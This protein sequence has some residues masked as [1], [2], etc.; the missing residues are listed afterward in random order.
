MFCLFCFLAST[1]KYKWIIICLTWN[2][3]KVSFCL[4]SYADRCYDPR[5]IWNHLRP[6]T[7][8]WVSKFSPT[9]SPRVVN[10]WRLVAYPMTITVGFFFF[11]P[12]GVCLCSRP[13]ETAFQKAE[14]WDHCITRYFTNFISKIRPSCNFPL[15]IRKLKIALKQFGR[16]S[17]KGLPI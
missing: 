15:E 10:S 4:S 16:Q 13:K 11:C 9:Y 12:S 6:E 3:R 7:E 2:T 8:L 17:G 5:G 1:Y 14:C